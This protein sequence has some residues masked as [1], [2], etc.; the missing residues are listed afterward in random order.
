MKQWQIARKHRVLNQFI[1][2]HFFRI[3][4][5]AL[6]YNENSENIQAATKEGE[7]RYRMAYPKKHHGEHV[8]IKPIKE[9][10]TYGK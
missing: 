6:H 7:Q 9:K 4:L 2:F 5:A 8:V 1:I 10:P 3:Y